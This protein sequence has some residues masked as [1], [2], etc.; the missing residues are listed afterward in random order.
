MNFK[1]YESKPV[2]RLAHEVTDKDVITKV[3]EAT[4]EIVSGEDSISFKA[5]EAVK[6]GDF[7]VFLNDKDVYHCNRKVFGDRNYI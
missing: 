6:T 1:E 7:I 2:V 5:Y 4:F 3:G